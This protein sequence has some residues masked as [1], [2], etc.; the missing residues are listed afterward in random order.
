MRRRL[1]FILIAGALHLNGALAQSFDAMPFRAVQRESLAADL[2]VSLD[3][4]GNAQ[5]LWQ[6]EL[7]LQLEWLQLQDGEWGTLPAESQLS[8]QHWPYFH[9]D[10]VL[11]W[12][13]RSSESSA[14]ASMGY[15]LR[16]AHEVESVERTVRP[17]SSVGD[18]GTSKL[19]ASVLHL[20][21]SAGPL[22]VAILA[23]S[24]T[25]ARWNESVQ[26]WELPPARGAWQLVVVAAESDENLWFDIGQALRAVRPNRALAEWSA[27]TLCERCRRPIASEL[28][29]QTARENGS[30]LL[31]I[32]LPGQELDREHGQ[33]IYS[34]LRIGSIPLAGHLIDATQNEA[35]YRIA[36]DSEFAASLE[37]ELKEPD[38]YVRLLSQAGQSFEFGGLRVN[39]AP[40]AREVHPSADFPKHLSAR[41]L[42]ATPNPFQ[43]LTQIRVLVPGSVREAFDL[44]ADQL[45]RFA[46]S[47]APFGQQPMLRLRVYN[48]KGKLVR[49]LYAA[50]H[51]IGELS[52]TWNGEDE[53]GRPVASGA[54]YVNLSLGQH[55]VTHRIT[56]L[57]P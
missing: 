39:L 56:L 26:L 10:S 25:P 33:P 44:D 47:P 22:H 29:V 17:H 6:G 35:R 38:T 30:L 4:Q 1:H 23:L 28:H 15:R 53:Q 41:L 20:D 18:A 12:E 49:V 50:T 34:T 36:A 3:A 42:S 40:E 14:A 52:V 31:R 55:D 2:R 19:R 24:P 45:Q 27:P 54:Y 51:R 7:L 48:V 37:R 11:L 32:A 13:V 57:N 9:L 5:L 8:F 16:T 21:G 46:A 43:E